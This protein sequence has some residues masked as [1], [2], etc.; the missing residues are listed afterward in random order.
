MSWG[1]LADLALEVGDIVARDDDELPAFLARFVEEIQVGRV[2][3]QI[4][5]V[6]FPVFPLGH[7]RC[8]P[9]GV[10]RSAPERHE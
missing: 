8:I 6:D 7:L 3:G 4:A 2:P 5:E 10:R 9:N 1:L